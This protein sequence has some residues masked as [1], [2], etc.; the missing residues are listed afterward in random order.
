[1]E[2]GAPR[3]RKLE[4]SSS[5]LENVPPVSDCDANDEEADGLIPLSAQSLNSCVGLLKSDP[6][7]SNH[8]GSRAC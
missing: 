5:I 1:M 4:I 2:P 8:A 3:R 7:V 6:G